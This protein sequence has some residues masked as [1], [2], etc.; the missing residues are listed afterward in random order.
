MSCLITMSQKELH[1]LELIQR[2]RGGDPTAIAAD[3]LLVVGHRD[4]LFCGRVSAPYK[5]SSA[6][7]GNDRN[8]FEGCLRRLDSG[9][10]RCEERHRAVGSSS[11]GVRRPI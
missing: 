5:I 3:G 8:H 9:N 11:I 1:R 10:S 4:L 6:L 2:I 7:S